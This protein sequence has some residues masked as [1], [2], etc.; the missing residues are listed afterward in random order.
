MSVTVPT[1]KVLW[2]RARNQCA[3]PGCLQA[4]TSDGVHATTGD[5]LVTVVGEQGHIRSSKVDGPRHDPNYDAAKLD[6]YENLI[7][8]CPT[9]HTMVDANGG[10]EFGVE[11]L[12]KIRKDHEDRHD[13]RERI[14]ATLRA[15]SVQQFGV[16]DKVLFEQVDLNGPSVD[17]MFVDVP[18]ACRPDSRV[19]GL[20]QQ[21]ASDYPGDVEAANVADGQIVTGAA[22]SLLHPYW[23]GNALLIGGPGQGKSTLLQYVCQFY[24][25]R[26]LDRVDYSGEEQQLSKLTDR[27][28]VPIRLDLRK[29]A[30]W[31]SAVLLNPGE[32]NRRRNKRKGK[33]KTP[34]HWPSIEEYIAAEIKR[35]SG[36]RQ[37]TVEDL[38]TLVST[39]PVLIAL[40]GLDEVANLHSRE[41]VSEEIVK[42]EARLAVDAMDLQVLVASRPGS[43]TSEL[44]SSADFPRLTLQ[45]LT[46]GLRLQY[47][48]RW[49]VVAKLSQGATDKLARTFMEQ[50]NVP[51]I[52]ELA[53]YPMQLAILLHL[54]H[55]RQ[56]LP[57]RRTELYCEYLKTFLDREQRQ[58]K[59]PLLSEERQV[60]EDIHAF[61]GWYIQTKAEEGRGSG[62]IRRDDLKRVLREHL[63]GR[64]NGQKLADKLFSAF[65]TRVLCLVERDPGWFQFDVQ[66]LREYFAA[67]Y[68]FEESERN[69]RD[70][71]LNALLRR[72]YWSNV[73]RFFVGNYAKGEVRGIRHLLQ[74]LSKE[75]DLGLHPMLRST[76]TL[77]LN[78]RTYEGQK[79]NPIQEVVDFILDGPGV[80]IAEDGLLDVAG[81]AFLLSERAGRTQAVQH[82]KRRLEGGASIGVGEA[83]ASS[84][85]RHAV[86]EDDI[87]AWWWGRFEP[88]WE[89]FQRASLLGVL[90]E[91]D[92]EQTTLLAGVLATRSADASWVTP[93]L[94]DGGYD[95]SEDSVLGFVKAEINDGAAELVRVFD[96]ASPVGRLLAAA[97]VA[98]LRLSGFGNDAGG[99]YVPGRRLRGKP[100]DS[101]FASVVSSTNEL[102]ARPSATA[103]DD[104]W[105]SWL[106]CIAEAWGEGWVLRQSVA[107]LPADVGIRSIAA[108]VKSSRFDLHAILM[109][110]ACGRENRGDTDWWRQQLEST[111]GDASAQRHLIFSLL[112]C[113]HTRVVIDLAREL[114]ALVDSLAPKHYLTIREGLR[115]FEGLFIH[116][117]LSLQEALR[118]NK[119]EFSARTLWLLRVAS[120]RGSIEYIDKRLADAFEELLA[121]G[122]GDLRELTR[123]VGS[124]KT[125][126]LETLR[127]HRASLPVGGWASDIK[128]GA[129]RLTLAEQM[130][131]DPGEWPG[132]LVQRAV[133]KIEA[134]MLA[135]LPAISEVAAS[136]GW[137][138]EA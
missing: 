107:A 68:L 9:H 113:A 14:E 87:A 127:G 36:G 62:S 5:P 78:D 3:F 52:R 1:V 22:Q 94:V 23:S 28:R 65:T 93:L 47:L 15:Y 89:W 70:D 32:Q 19:S 37:F 103:R 43:T 132:D 76:A 112:S 30:T 99:L 137:F 109:T 44:W 80:V 101:V 7:L 42:T 59:E 4:L 26:L 10:A 114:D 82:L 6:S 75:P 111:S 108:S 135:G 66:S 105:R 50:Q 92:Q 119:V 51:H 56:L 53:S 121:S 104:E 29:Y 2:T 77:F 49:A 73:C 126:R 12:V 124:G 60:I 136:D 63:A 20:M 18:F 98:Q 128:P 71:C 118:L 74:D 97:A 120:T 81:S 8:L 110:E 25:A 129:L 11:T 45:R 61:I 106:E 134:R 67:L 41:R 17:S 57:Q 24:R 123:I 54:L 122:I 13:R 64:D 91:L 86:P 31:A 85:R 117:Q 58:D 88:D 39:R 72:P 100:A 131:K 90:G 33:E 83:L 35:G 115:A 96:R 95:G 138:S 102:G 27:K 38:G 55:R 16:D 69:S 34:S 84:L 116:R 21:I 133:Q 46:N 125:I 130:L 79:D 48:H 40:D